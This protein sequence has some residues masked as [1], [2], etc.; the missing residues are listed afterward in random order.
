MKQEVISII[1][2]LEIVVYIIIK[3]KEEKEVEKII[4]DVKS[5]LRNSEFAKLVDDESKLENKYKELE[6]SFN[7]VYNAL[8]KKLGP[9]FF[10]V[11][12]EILD[13]KREIS[14]E[15]KNRLVKRYYTRPDITVDKEER[16]ELVHLINQFNN[17]RADLDRLISKLE[18]GLSERNHGRGTR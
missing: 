7:S 10:D 8:K 9:S 6:S 4:N 11:Y 3:T 5:L 2:D 12:C 18:V 13:T 15:L 1:F 17:K 16:Q 14:S